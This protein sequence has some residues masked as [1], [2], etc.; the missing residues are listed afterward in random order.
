MA[1]LTHH[2]VHRR[3]RPEG[4]NQGHA[5]PSAEEHVDTPRGTTRR[6]ANDNTLRYATNYLRVRWARRWST[7]SDQ[8]QR[9]RLDLTILRRSTVR[10]LSATLRIIMDNL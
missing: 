1:P 8:K 3:Q 7:T 2:S 4:G 5:N 9:A 6:R 10:L